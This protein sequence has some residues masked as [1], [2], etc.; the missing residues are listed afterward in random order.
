M[1]GLFTGSFDPITVGHVDIIR[2]ALDQVD[3][4]IV[5]V[6]NNEQK[7]YMCDLHTRVN[8]VTIALKSMDNIR[9]LGSNGLV[10]DFCIEHGVDVI[11]RGFRNSK[12][13]EYELEMAVFNHE[14]SGVLTCILPASEDCIGMSSTIAREYYVSG[15][16]MDKI[17][18]TEVAGELRRFG[19]E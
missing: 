9:I 10:S 14:N 15:I 11:Y 4:L 17:I 7:S 12:D 16:D 1:I 6:F 13:Y 3:S 18:P 5:G 2:R 19:N 8:L